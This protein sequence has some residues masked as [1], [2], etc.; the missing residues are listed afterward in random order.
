MTSALCLACGE[1]VTRASPDEPW[2]GEDGPVC[3]RRRGGHQ[4]EQIIPDP[5]EGGR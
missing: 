1:L 3:S 5:P 4:V 2:E